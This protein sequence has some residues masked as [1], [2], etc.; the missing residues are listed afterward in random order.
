MIVKKLPTSIVLISIRFETIRQ[1]QKSE[2]RRRNV[3]EKRGSF[4]VLVF[5]EV[6]STR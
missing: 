1:M 4:I 2:E 6:A 5:N 3:K